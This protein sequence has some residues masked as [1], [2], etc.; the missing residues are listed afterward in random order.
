MNTYPIKRLTLVTD[1]WQPQVNGVV[2]TLFQLVQH[3]QKTGIEVDVMHPYDY[4]FFG[5]PTYR[6]IPIV[7]QAKNLEQRIEQFQPDALH[8][9][10]EGSLGWRA[11]RW[12]IKNKVAFTTAYHTKYPE[13]LRQRFPIPAK[14]TYQLLAHFHQAAQRTFVPAQAILTELTVRGFNNLVMMSRGVDQTVFNPTQAIE[15]PYPKPILLYVGRIAVEKN[16]EAFL[17]LP[18]AGTKLLIGDGPAKLHLQKRYTHA[19]FIGVKTGQE[20]AQY[21]ASSD[22]MVFPSL[23]DTFGLVNIEAM[24]CGTPVAAFPV[25]GPID[26][27][28]HGLNGAL[29]EDLEDA[30]EEALGLDRDGIAPSVA[31][32]DWSEVS[33]AFLNHLAFIAP[34]EQNNDETSNRM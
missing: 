31:H 33:H 6:E 25:T 5:L 24:A 27:I 2:T 21:Y 4:H 10:T 18:I 20:L 13:Y 29:S 14:W 16:L 26:I 1:A 23:T 17:N 8:I 15:L 19:H 32:Y 22:V 12:A 28:T 30:V 34:S 3:L 11:R 9:A 7:W